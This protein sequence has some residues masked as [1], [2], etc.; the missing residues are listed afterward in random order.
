MTTIYRLF[1]GAVLII[2]M[3]S[4]FSGS[5]GSSA[6]A[7]AIASLSLPSITLPASRVEGT[8]ATSASAYPSSHSM[9]A[10]TVSTDSISDS[11]LGVAFTHLPSGWSVSPSGLY[12]SNALT[13]VAGNDLRLSVQ[14]VS[15]SDTTSV[16]SAETAAVRQ[17]TRDLKSLSWPLPSS[18]QVHLG[19]CLR[20]CPVRLTSRL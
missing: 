4:G 19:S 6:A 20:T 7:G 15:L 14:P 18:S 11:A 1:L 12:S 8:R 9:S 16:A 2:C 17:L 10:T 5:A 3:I 13:L